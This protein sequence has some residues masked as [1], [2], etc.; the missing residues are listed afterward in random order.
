MKYIIK[1]LLILMVTLFIVSIFT[2]TAFEVIPGDS[3][4]ST[5]GMDASEEAIA[6]LR[7]ERGLNDSI[8]VR[9][10][11]WLTN[12]IQG[13]FGESTHY[14][15][16]VK[17]LVSERLFVTV[18]LALL[19]LL[20]IVVISFPLGIFSVGIQ[21]KIGNQI[22]VFFTHLVMAIPSFFLGMLLTLL[23]GVALRW[24]VPGRY[25]SFTTNKVEFLHYM[26]YPALAMAIPKIAMMVKFL[27]SSIKRQMGHDYVRTAFSKGNSKN[28]VLNRHILKNALIP[29][30]TFLGM[31]IADVFAGSIVVEQVFNLPGIGRLLVVAI[32]SRDY[33]VVQAVVLYISSIVV[34]VN[35]LVDV[36][37][38]VIDPRIGKEGGAK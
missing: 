13:D 25:I 22:A 34:I 24:F 9:Y 5:L 30:I 16:P 12:V 27:R 28:R 4:L 21:S 19:A 36:I 32:S 26:I 18:S 38:R 1:K 8:V 20:L 3:A 10:V 15:I 29:V 14:S 33:A 11:K 35:L 2:F 23:F 6:Q 17:E 7:E 31:I 37:Y